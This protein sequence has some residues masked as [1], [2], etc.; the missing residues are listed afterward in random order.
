MRKGIRW[1]LFFFGVMAA[2]LVLCLWA[3]SGTRTLA[4][5]GALSADVAEKSYVLTGWKEL[6]GGEFTIALPENFDEPLTLVFCDMNS[7]SLFCD[8]EEI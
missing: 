5:G 3:G 8:G 1:L 6:S 7:F 2:V 4:A